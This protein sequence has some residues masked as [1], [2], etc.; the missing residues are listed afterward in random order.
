MTDQ[1]AP[2]AMSAVC[3]HVVAAVVG[4][5]VGSAIGV[6]RS[7]RIRPITVATGIAMAI[8]VVGITIA[9]V[10]VGA[11]GRGASFDATKT[12]RSAA[13]ETMQS[14]R[15]VLMATTGK[16]ARRCARAATRRNASDRSGWRTTEWKTAGE[17]R[18]RATGNGARRST[19]EHRRRTRGRAELRQCRVGRC[20]GGAEQHARGQGKNRSLPTLCVSFDLELWLSDHRIC[21][22]A[23]DWCGRQRHG[24]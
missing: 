9:G 3:G 5:G 6:S 15:T 12:G 22:L 24:L 11:V 17:T 7:R 2:G 8:A 20:D 19:S 10:A 21:P 14:G 1:N 18:R 4:G 16:I 23:G 13:I